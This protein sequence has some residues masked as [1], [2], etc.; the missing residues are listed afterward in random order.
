M[1]V[2]DIFRFAGTK[3]LF[4]QH[5]VKMTFQAK[6]INLG[7]LKCAAAV[8]HQCHRHTGGTQC[9]QHLD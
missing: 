2:N 6:S 5:V 3:L 7:A 4:D 9:L 8:G 1:A